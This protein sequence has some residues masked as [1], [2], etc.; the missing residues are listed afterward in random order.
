MSRC[1]TA[2]MI[3]LL[4]GVPAAQAAERDA[5]PGASSGV[6]TKSPAS[7]EEPMPGDFWTYE[8]RDEIGGST[9]VRKSIVTEV[10]PGDIR[11]DITGGK[12]GDRLN[13]YD[14]SWNLK[15]TGPWKYQPIDGSGI[16][17][18]L[19]VGAAW[20]V[21]ADDVNSQNGN[22]FR[23]SVNSKVVGQETITTKAGRFDTFK[24]RNDRLQTLDQRSVQEG[25]D[26]GADLVCTS[27]RSLG[28]AQLRVSGR[29][30][31]GEQQHK[32]ARRIRS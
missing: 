5:L 6:E 7:M 9:E 31:F 30:S 23:R 17:M 18:P 19:K 3:C 21:T 15:S 11:V 27:D 28:Q 8:V 25:R 24:I 29:Q 1:A 16:R 2:A 22:I 13:I 32:R 12:S 20:N 26:H 14:R 4:A 10:N